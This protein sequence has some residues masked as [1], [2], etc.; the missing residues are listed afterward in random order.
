MESSY[1]E[2]I[3]VVPDD[4][5][6]YIT[7]VKYSYATRLSKRISERILITFKSGKIVEYWSYNPMETIFEK[8]KVC[9]DLK[10]FFYQNIFSKL[11]YKIINK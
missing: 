8:L 1:S 11:F 2:E 4:K 3:Y 9:S 10:S 5:N 7:S 6:S